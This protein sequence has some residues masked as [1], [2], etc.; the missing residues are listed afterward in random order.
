MLFLTGRFD[1]DVDAGGQGQLVQR[2]DR[3]GRRLN[4]VD[5]PLVR[6]NFKLLAGFFVDVRTGKNRIA[7]D[8]GG[9]RNR[10]TNNGTGS[11]GRIDDF[12]CTLIKHGM[13]EGFHSNANNFLS[14]SAHGQSPLVLSQIP[15]CQAT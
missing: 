9:K 8:P 10:A 15:N 7:F 4:D 13:I 1:F 6:A 11:F 3:F 2:V 14:E 12:S 5:D